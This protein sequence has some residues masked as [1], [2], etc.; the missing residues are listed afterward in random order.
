M[1]RIGATLSLRSDLGG[2]GLRGF[3]NR[4]NLLATVIAATA[5]FGATQRAAAIPP[6]TAE[7]GLVAASFGSPLRRIA[8]P[9]PPTPSH[10]PRYD[11]RASLKTYRTLP[12]GRIDYSRGVQETLRTD[13]ISAGRYE[14]I[15]SYTVPTRASCIPRLVLGYLVLRS[16]GT[17]GQSAETWFFRGSAVA[18]GRHVFNLGSRFAAELPITSR[19]LKFRFT[20]H[21]CGGANVTSGPTF[22][23]I[24]GS[25][26]VRPFPSARLS[27]SCPLGG[28]VGTVATIAGRLQPAIS[29]ASVTLIYTWANGSISDYVAPTNVNGAFEDSFNIPDSPGRWKAEA[30]WT[31]NKDYEP[32]SAE[33]MFDVVAGSAGTG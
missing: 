33:C 3:R 31:G 10:P 27:I 9:P 28:G 21:S 25:V 23:P 30:R 12:N 4:R 7:T 22:V 20:Y 26:R 32:L 6:H 8:S 11:L 15:L 19:P 17:I 16:N 18:P 2:S 1:L 29:G 13:L 14:T 24:A 5:I